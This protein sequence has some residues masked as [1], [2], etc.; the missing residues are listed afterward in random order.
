MRYL[1]LMR[2][3]KAEPGSS[4][5][6]HGRGLT[7]R[8]RAEAQEAGRRIAEMARPDAV[9]L[10]DS[11]RTRET[12]ESAAPALPADLPREATRTLYAATAET[13]LDTVRATSDDV[14]CLLVIGH[15]P[16]I[17]DLARR[18]AGEGAKRDLARLADGFP[19][20]C[21]AVLE[22]DAARWS[23]IGRPGRLAFLLPADE[24]SGR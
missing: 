6:D 23:E 9:L 21:F 3:G 5:G 10:S 14:A 7:A 16:G 17:G 18:L 13:I 1:I 12:L 15:N 8:G 20:S 2:H 11:T 24:R 4:A 19:T 22:I